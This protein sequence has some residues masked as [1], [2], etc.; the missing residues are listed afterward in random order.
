MGKH[1][2]EHRSMV[3]DATR[4]NDHPTRGDPARSNEESTEHTDNIREVEMEDKELQQL[5]Q[6][7]IG[8][9]N[10]SKGPTQKSSDPRTTQVGASRLPPVNIMT[11]EEGESED[12]ET[13]HQPCCGLQLS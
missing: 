13:Q 8:Q 6:Q 12:R 2:F 10:H 5:E 7:A 11:T 1:G 4:T 9:K 3:R